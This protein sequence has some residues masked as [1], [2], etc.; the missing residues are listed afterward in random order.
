MNYVFPFQQG[1][2]VYNDGKEVQ[3]FFDKLL[4][5][6]FPELEL[7][8][9]AEED[10]EEDWWIVKTHLYIFFEFSSNKYV[11]VINSFA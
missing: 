1:S 11:H 3:S 5:R 9:Q 8:E 10:D 6:Y 4:R 2:D 7:D